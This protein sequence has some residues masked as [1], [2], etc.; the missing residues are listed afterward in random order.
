MYAQS[1]IQ[2]EPCPANRHVIV[3]SEIASCL[4]V[5]KVASAESLDEGTGISRR[6][7]LHDVP[8]AS[9]SRA[10][11]ASKGAFAPR[12]MSTETSDRTEDFR[13]RWITDGPR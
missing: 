3:G 10:K 13:I 5:S 8:S 2:S 7:K 12:H 6:V 9:S 1:N 11:L 4:V